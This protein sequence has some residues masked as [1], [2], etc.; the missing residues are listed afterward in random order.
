M[1]QHN[2]SLKRR[3]LN[4]VFLV[5]LT[6]VSIKIKHCVSRPVRTGPRLQST[7]MTRPCT[8]E[9]RTSAQFLQIT[10]RACCLTVRLSGAEGVRDYQHVFNAPFTRVRTSLYALTQFFLLF[11]GDHTIPPFVRHLLV[12]VKSSTCLLASPTPFTHHYRQR[13]SASGSIGKKR[14]DAGS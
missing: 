11:P 8:F 9:N 13:R 6:R 2:T 1:A 4:V 5:N 3:P 14:R 10:T 7:F 12:H